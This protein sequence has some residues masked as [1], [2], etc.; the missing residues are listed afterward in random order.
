MGM[1]ICKEMLEDSTGG[2]G[3]TGW[4]Q[5]SGEGHQEAQG[6]VNEGEEDLWS[7]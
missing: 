1:G 5:V 7:Y 2:E 6:R 3:A 4:V